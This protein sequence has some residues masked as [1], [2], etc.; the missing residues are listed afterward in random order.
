MKNENG[1]EVYTRPIS[2][3]EF[4]KFKKECERNEALDKDGKIDFIKYFKNI[5]ERRTK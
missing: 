2:K 5:K 4:T 3:K 1:Y